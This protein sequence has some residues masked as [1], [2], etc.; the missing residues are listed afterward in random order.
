MRNGGENFQRFL[1]DLRE[2]REYR[3]ISLSQVAEETRIN[4]EYLE[5]LET[6][7]WDRVSGP[8]L[9]GYL[10]SYAE[11]VGM[12]RDKVLRRF[13]ELDY[14]SDSTAGR[15]FAEPRPVERAPEPATPAPRP[16]AR[17]AARPLPE[18]DAA[19]A[20]PAPPAVPPLW[21]VIP[22]RVKIAGGGLL[23]AVAAALVWGLFGLL[24]LGGPAEGPQDFERTLE[25][26]RSEAES[27]RFV[28]QHFDPCD[29]RFRL[30]RPAA[31]RAFTRDSI[32]F[33]GTLKA[34]SLLT[35]SS[36]AEMTLQVERLEDLELF[37]D[38]GAVELPADSGRA[39]VRVS[40]RGAS[41]IRRSP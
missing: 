9:R 26:A 27:K 3:G 2:A 10:I 12:V 23:L 28:L 34:D 30:K 22:G 33:A 11:C 6:G 16:A 17:P 36:T 19:P 39:E 38:G 31:L 14:R 40:R 5:A 15:S 32:H 7:D 37:L 29:I 35:L 20:E 1:R 41:V 25:D 21:Q 24:R 4:L 8:Y 18:P 13:E